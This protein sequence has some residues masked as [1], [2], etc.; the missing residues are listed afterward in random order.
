[1]SDQSLWSPARGPNMSGLT[2]VFGGRIDFL[3]T[4]VTGLTGIGNQ[5]DRYLLTDSKN[6]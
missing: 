6:Q 3:E 2:G 5:S 4:I 1:M